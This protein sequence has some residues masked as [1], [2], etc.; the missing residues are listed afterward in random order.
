[1]QQHNYAA[2]NLLLSNLAEFCVMEICGY[3][4]IRMCMMN[5]ITPYENNQNDDFNSQNNLSLNNS[6][7]TRTSKSS[8]NTININ[9]LKNRDSRNLF[10]APSD[11]K[12]DNKLAHKLTIFVKISFGDN[13]HFVMDPNGC[14]IFTKLQ[15]EDDTGREY[16]EDISNK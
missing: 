8:K 5:M 13:L 15:I 1:M 10:E 4:N 11:E 7:N 12:D 3:N 9:D 2:V 6:A 16:I 14:D